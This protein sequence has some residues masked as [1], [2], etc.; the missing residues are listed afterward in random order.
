M[1]ILTILYQDNPKM[2]L[3]PIKDTSQSDVKELDIVSI[4]ICLAHHIFSC[5]QFAIQVTY[6]VYFIPKHEPYI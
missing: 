1:F 3:G 5:L 2:D 4:C 6:I